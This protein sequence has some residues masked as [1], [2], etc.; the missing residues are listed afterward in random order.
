MLVVKRVQ[1]NMQ[2]DYDESEGKARTVLESLEV[3]IKQ[4]LQLHDRKQKVH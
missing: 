4:L 1:T 3:N 2:Q